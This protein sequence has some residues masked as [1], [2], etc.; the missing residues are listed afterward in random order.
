MSNELIQLTRLYHTMLGSDVVLLVNLRVVLI[1][2]SFHIIPGAL[3][4]SS[5]IRIL[6]LYI[7]TKEKL[8]WIYYGIFGTVEYENTIV[9]QSI[10]GVDVGVEIVGGH[11]GVKI[12]HDNQVRVEHAV[13]RFSHQ[14][15]STSVRYFCM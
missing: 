12:G 6:I 10:N 2:E 14:A 9:D 4:S 11:A 8:T 1:V 3:N 7:R 15:E 5:R 13:E